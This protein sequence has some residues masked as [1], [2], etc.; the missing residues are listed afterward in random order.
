[1]TDFRRTR[2]CL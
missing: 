2:A 1:M